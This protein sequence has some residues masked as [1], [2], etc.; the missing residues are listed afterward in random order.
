MDTAA[1]LA[2]NEGPL[3]PSSPAG[4]IWTGVFLAV[5]LVSAVGIAQ[6]ENRAASVP[7]LFSDV[8][9][10]GAPFSATATTTVTVD[11]P[12]GHQVRYV[13]QAHYFRDADGRV[14][15][16][17]GLPSAGH[18]GE[19]DT[20]VVLDPD[21]GDRVVY[22]LQP[23]ARRFSLGTIGIAGVLFNGDAF[24]TPLAWN[25]FYVLK[26][27]TG[28]ADRESPGSVERLG[29]QRLAGVEVN[30][31]RTTRP[32][33]SGPSVTH[34]VDERWESADLKIVVWSRYVDPGHGTFEYRLTDIRRVA[35][36]PD[37]F[38]IPTDYSLY[39]TSRQDPLVVLEAPPRTAADR[40]ATPR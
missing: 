11:G 30:G 37:L 24:A 3:M 1:A 12:D 22:S 13:S 23:M 14:R 8:P 39:H 5:L 18:D 2:T 6:D 33:L 36:A 10:V 32:A 31:R 29:V 38:T 9:T 25:R 7:G 26:P 15:V 17:L 35:A 19:E 21:P 20:L 16:E 40:S 34:A 27:A 28:I 4:R